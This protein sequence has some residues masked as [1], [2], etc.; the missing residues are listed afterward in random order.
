MTEPTTKAQSVTQDGD[1]DGFVPPTCYYSERD[2][3]GA[4]RL[5]LS[6]P[7]DELRR[8]HQALVRDCAEPLQV[9][10]RQVVDR[11]DPK[12][13]GTPSR[14][15]VG[16]GMSADEVIEAFTAADSLLYR[17]A[18]CEV[19]VRDAGGAQVVLDCD[20]LV[21]IY[22]DDISSRTVLDD[23]GILMERSQTIANR[24]YVRHAFHASCDAVEDAFIEG[25]HLTE[26]A[27]QKRT[28]SKY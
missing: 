23:L 4:T 10:Y 15:F 16:L 14:D 28:G 11:R 24:D 17:D 6:A 13:E 22:P 20:G 12:P 8:A 21:F 18:R 19:W 27:P 1:L 2:P 3:G 9:L 7:V 26:V 5:V 25:L